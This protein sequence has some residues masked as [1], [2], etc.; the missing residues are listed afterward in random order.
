MILV[1]RHMYMHVWGHA[2]DIHLYFF[3]KTKKEII[4]GDF[5][6]PVPGFVNH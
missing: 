6:C 3:M 5:R 2:V 4:P 1:N